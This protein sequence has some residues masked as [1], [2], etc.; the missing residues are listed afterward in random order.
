MKINIRPRQ[1]ISCL[2]AALFIFVFA[3]YCSGRVGWFLLLALIL[4]PLFS[5][6][7]TILCKKNLEIKASLDHDLMSRGDHCTLTVS[8]Y[9]KGL[10]PCPPVII[11]IT[12]REGLS[13]DSVSL[14]LKLSSLPKKSSYA[15]VTF[16]AKLS[17]GVFIGAQSVILS[18]YFGI[19]STRLDRKD[20]FIFKAGVIPGIAKMTNTSDLLLSVH[21]AFAANKNDETV[22][23]STIFFGGFP[24]YEYRE[25]R[26]GDPL[27]RINSKLSAKRDRLMVRLDERQASSNIIFVLD[28]FLEEED[29][30]LSQSV[31]EESLGMILTLMN[32]DFS[33]SFYYLMDG[34]WFLEK[35]FSEDSLVMLSRKLAY[36]MFT[37]KTDFDLPEKEREDGSGVIICQAKSSSKTTAK[38]SGKGF[39]IYSVSGGEWRHL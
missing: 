11:N 37:D 20:E 7:L 25:Y 22:D 14:I 19:V 28:P 16:T 1:I 23:E 10:L 4:T 9:N 18:D 3:L 15:K 33:V 6:L 34:K 31:L 13:A 2:F 30:V 29:P 21:D 36:F 27:K 17:G 12:E 32:L 8:L 26:P 39:H 38:L 24:G 35:I 5:V